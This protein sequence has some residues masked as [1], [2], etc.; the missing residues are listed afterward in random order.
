MKKTT[1]LT[2][3]I[4]GVLLMPV[5]SV[6]QTTASGTVV[7]NATVESSISMVFNSDGSGVPLA[8]GNSNA[9]T[10]NF[11]NISA[12]GALSPNVGRVVGGANFTVSTPFDVLVNASNTAVAN[13]KLTAQLAANDAT[14]TWVLGGVT[15]TNA[16]PATINGTNGYGV[17]TPYTLA[18]TVPLASSAGAISNTINFTATAN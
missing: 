17:N 14:N 4:A 10:L 18:L 9:A 8:G 3:L 15:V 13:C 6:A 16:A 12:Y 2:I 1:L 7:V 5:L 11:G